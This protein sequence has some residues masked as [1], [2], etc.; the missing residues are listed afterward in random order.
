MKNAILLTMLALASLAPGFGQ[1]I[2]RKAPDLTVHYGGVRQGT[3]GD[4]GGKVMLVMFFLT[5][6]PHCQHTTEL[7]NPIQTELGKQGFQVVGV[8]I[9]QD[10]QAKLDEFKK[11]YKPAFPVAY[12]D[13]MDAAAF[14]SLDAT[15]RIVAP[16]LVF[17]DRHG[18]IR[19]QTSGDDATFFNDK[20]SDNIRDEAQKL[21]AEPKK[22][23]K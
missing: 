20:E 8:A 18:M 11:T 5:G 16:I 12:S 15:K 7:L 19:F 3:L 4:Y 13:Y 1:Q 9:N 22:G 14:T 17:I 6:C 21:L 2:P 23:R 10:A